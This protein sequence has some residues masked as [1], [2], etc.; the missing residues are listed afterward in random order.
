MQPIK[1]IDDVLT[2]LD[3]IIETSKEMSSPLG[4]FAALYRKVTQKVKDGI[5]AKN[6][7][8]NNPRMERLD[9]IFASRYIDAYRAYQKGETTTLSWMEAFDLSKKYWPIV[10]QHLLIGMNAHIN[11]DLGIAAA[12]VMQ[13]K[14]IDDL[15]DDFNK[16]NEILADLVGDVEKDLTEIWPRLKWV[17]KYTHTFDDFLI[18]F[19]MKEARE[20]AWK[21]AVQFH[22]TV[23][24]EQPAAIDARDKKVAKIGKLVVRPP[25]LVRVI[26]GIIRLG[27]RGTVAEKIQ[28]MES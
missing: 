13:G 7:F 12:E 14:D 6:V 4:Y 21:F 2:A 26:F 19:S 27:E 25:W 5:E 16:I 11:L 28:D 22:G 10:L 1:T 3:E 18:N 24:S 17:L 15:E 9:V 20:G 8:Q 23:Q